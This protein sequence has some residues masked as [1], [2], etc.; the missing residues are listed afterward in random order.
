RGVQLLGEPLVVHPRT[1]GDVG[2]VELAVYRQTRERHIIGCPAGAGSLL[3]DAVL[4]VDDRRFAGR[5]PEREVHAIGHGSERL[6][7]GRLVPADLPIA[8]PDAP[9]VEAD[10]G[11][12]RTGAVEALEVA[13]MASVDVG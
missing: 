7:I 6:H 2:A 13:G 9:L 3:A 12:S 10:A 1:A 8:V 5:Q 4:A 11:D